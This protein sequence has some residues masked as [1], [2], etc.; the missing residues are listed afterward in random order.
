MLTRFKDFVWAGVFLSILIGAQS[1]VLLKWSIKD[2][3]PLSWDESVHTLNA[4]D[5]RK[6]LEEGPVSSLLKKPIYF[7]YPPLYHLM[8]AKSL[9]SPDIADSGVAVNIFFL[10]LLVAATFFLAYDLL[11]YWPA[12]AAAVLVSSYPSMIELLPPP[13][14]DLPL[15]AVVAFA[16]LCLVKSEHFGRLGWSLGFGAALGVGFLLKWTAGIYVMGPLAVEAWIAV[17]NRSYK[18]L[19]FSILV[20]IVVMSP[21][22]AANFFSVLSMFSKV[23]GN[24]PAGGIILSSWLSP[25]WYPFALPQLMGLLFLI[26]FLPSLL[27][28]CWNPRFRIFTLWAL[29]SIAV[30]TLI[31]NN[32][33][34]RYAVPVLPALAILSVAWIPPQ[35]KAPFVAIITASL[36]YFGLWFFYQGPALSF[37]I[38]KIPVPLLVSNPPQVVDWKHGDIISTV[39]E[40]KSKDRPHTQVVVLSNTPYFHSSSLNATLQ[41]KGVSDFIFRGPAKSRW[42]DFSE[43]ILLKTKEW[44]PEFTLG[45]VRPAAE[46]VLSSPSWFKNSYREAGRWILPDGSEAVLYQVHPVPLKQMDT[47]VMNLNL[48]EFKLPKVVLENMHMRA[49]PLTASETAVGLFKELS[50]SCDKLIYKDMPFENVSFKFIRP[51]VNLHRFLE[52]GEIQFFS[53]DT[54]KP[55]VDLSA[56]LILDYAAQKA[57]WLKNAQVLFEKEKIL[58]SGQAYGVPVHMVLGFKADGSSLSTRLEKVT[59]FGISLPVVILWN[60]THQKIPLTPSRDVPFYLDLAPIEGKNTYLSVGG[61]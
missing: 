57:K 1:A 50:I 15:T 42:M 2:T 45:N 49:V 21:W 22:Y 59:I 25:L 6:R 40:L 55:R 33:N 56:Q 13:M 26:L 35:Q 51:H 11:G 14:I 30:I 8:L 60:M 24:Q 36:L 58:I 27:F 31:T 29:V 37:Q 10:A 38:G 4:L 12:M 5:Y 39:Q 16:M 54:L 17:R 53:L 46:L 3:R 44:G 19:F 23:S 18:V 9:K 32:H 43:F 48:K 20:T 52:T 7:S 34:V 61:A 41:S 28:A 47:G